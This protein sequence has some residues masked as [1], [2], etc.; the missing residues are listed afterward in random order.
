MKYRREMSA[1]K[2][3]KILED[4]HYIKVADKHIIVFTDEDG[5]TEQV[6]NDYMKYCAH[7]GYTIEYR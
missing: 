2:H 7:N 6:V 5:E 3:M 1:D 4:R